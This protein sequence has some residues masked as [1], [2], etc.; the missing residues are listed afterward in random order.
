MTKIV[1]YGSLVIYLFVNGMCAWSW[2][3]VEHVLGLPDFGLV[4]CEFCW[5]RASRC[6]LAHGVSNDGHVLALILTVWSISSYKP[7]A[8]WAVLT[9]Y[10][11]TSDANWFCSVLSLVSYLIGWTVSWTLFAGLLACQ[12]ALESWLIGLLWLVQHLVSADRFELISEHTFSILH[13]LVVFSFSF[14]LEKLFRR[15]GESL[16][17]LCVVPCS[18]RL[19]FA[20][21]HFASIFCNCS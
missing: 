1:L 6:E 19:F 12:T 2:I 20:C 21:F 3:A 10:F 11:G 4:L 16:V 7:S 9:F 5:S 8:N 15:F 13:M 17:P 18:S 14:F